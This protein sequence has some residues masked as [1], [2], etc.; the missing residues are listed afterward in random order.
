M[1]YRITQFLQAVRPKLKAEEH[2][3]LNTLLGPAERSLFYRQSLP[4]Q[5]HALD[6]AKD[7]AGQV[8]LGENL[9]ELDYQN[10]MKAALLHDCGKSLL[11]LRLWQRVAVV[12][13]G[14]FSEEK[15]AALIKKRNIPGKI[16]IIHKQHAA[17]GK[18]LAAKAGL[19][20]EVQALIENHHAPVS[21][22]S[23]L[24][25]QADNRH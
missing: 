23:E 22:M 21:T 4:E 9:G 17:W 18:R 15:Q 24:L 8:F 3:W 12:L 2:A 5:R 11:K 20:D 1:F 25:R 14:L 7:L 19:N 13:L 6:V 10:L 16:L